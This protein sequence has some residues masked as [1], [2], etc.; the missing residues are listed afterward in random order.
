MPDAVASQW[1]VYIIRTASGS[2]YTGITTDVDRRFEE[3]S[4]TAEGKG[5]NGAKA[6]RG[7]AP[8]KIVFHSLIGNSSEALKMEYKIKQLTRKQKEEIVSSGLS[9]ADLVSAEA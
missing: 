6:L 8:L 1:H 5:G 4:Q 7:K 3:H 2:L 9:I